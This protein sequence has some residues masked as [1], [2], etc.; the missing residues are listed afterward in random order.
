MQTRILA[1]GGGELKTRETLKIDEY[2]A[3]EAKK[4][5]GE[6][7]ACGLFLPT[8]SHDCMPYYNTFHKIYTGLFGIK[9]DVLLVCNREPDFVKWQEKI[10]KADFL[11]VGGGDTVFMIEEWKR[12]GLL[13]L[14]RGAYEKGKFLCGQIGRASCRE[15]VYPLV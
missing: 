14:L 13:E 4:I 3:A 12:T 10:E 5:A 7:R 9:T 15:R 8:A 2:I 6:K 1:I 11:Y